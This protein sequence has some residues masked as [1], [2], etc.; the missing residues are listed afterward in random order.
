MRS[1]AGPLPRW[2]G[3]PLSAVYGAAVRIRN[4]RF[5]RGAGVTSPPVPVISV[6]NLSVGGVGKTP[7]VQRIA[8][9]LAAQGHRPA[10]LLRG[11]K[12]A[13]GAMS[14]EEAEHR[15]ALPNAIVVANPDRVGAVEALMS[16][17]INEQP[18]CVIL[19]DGFQHR[20]LGRTL[21]IVLIDARRD[22][23]R[24]ALL[25]AGWLR[26]SPSSLKRADAVVLTHADLVAPDEI[27]RISGL[28][29]KVSG[30]SP[31][32]M[33]RHAWSGVRVRTPDGQFTDHPTAWLNER[34]AAVICAIGEP[35][36]FLSMLREAGVEV[37]ST[38]ILQDHASFEP[39]AVQRVTETLSDSDAI[40]CTAK[41]WA[42]L[43]TVVL[44]G[45]SGLIAYPSVT[46]EA[47]RGGDNLDA[48]VKAAAGAPPTVE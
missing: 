39:A 2:I 34:R 9:L 45:F 6:G 21:D 36:Q 4:R 5:D 42:R 30:R 11:Y 18:T 7:M 29:E 19:D 40:I 3:A 26:E 24:D 20:R 33:V 37:V 12:S 16:R 25:P 32:A 38:L 17:P 8:R 43:A 13:A 48:L 14:D 31:A 44:E 23:W 10:V 22:P 15:A 27:E 47:L 46:I 41:D 28:V 1:D 35:D